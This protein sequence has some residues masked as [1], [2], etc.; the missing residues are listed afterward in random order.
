[1]VAMLHPIKQGLKLEVAHPD[2]PV[3]PGCYATSNKTRIET[4]SGRI[5]RKKQG[6]AMLHPI[7]QGLKLPRLAAKSGRSSVAM[8]HPIKQGLKPSAGGW[9]VYKKAVAMLHPIKQG[10]K[11]WLCKNNPL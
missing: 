4:D 8:L 3:H 2:H 6:V 1:M 5:F 9:S 7:K 10:L 11:L